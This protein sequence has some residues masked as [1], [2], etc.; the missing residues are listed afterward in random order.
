LS[1]RLLL[2]TN[3][4]SELM[5]DPRGR[6]AR[7]VLDAGVDNVCTSIIAAAELRYG[8]LTKKSLRLRREVEEL[9]DEIQVL[10]FDEPADAE[11]GKLRV[12]LEAA[13]KTLDANDLLIA[14]HA[15]AIGAS[16]VSA[17]AAF[18]RAGKLVSAV[19]W[20]RN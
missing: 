12:A 13:G 15:N 17:D 7:K 11:Y 8:A 19:S 5:N 14:S 9:L 16:V 2:D 1:R 4:L 10:S 18:R 6:I 3:I 20:P